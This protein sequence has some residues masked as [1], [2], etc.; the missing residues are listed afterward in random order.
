MRRPNPE[1]TRPH[2]GFGLA[3][4]E[5]GA[6]LEKDSRMGRGKKRY[7]HEGFSRTDKTSSALTMTRPLGHLTRLIFKLLHV[8]VLVSVPRLCL[9]R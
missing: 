7:A 1:R 4:Q 5:A 8:H 2:D 9:V 3:F 6:A